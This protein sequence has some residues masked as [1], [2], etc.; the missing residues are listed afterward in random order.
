MSI[1]IK[2]LPPILYQKQSLTVKNHI[3]PISKEALFLL[4]KCFL[5][6]EVFVQAPSHPPQ[7]DH[8]DIGETD[9][10]ENI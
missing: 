4:A 7:L 2:L 1:K 6:W 3:L 5:M 9:G 8:C 10:G